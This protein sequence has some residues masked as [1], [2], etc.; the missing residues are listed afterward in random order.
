MGVDDANSACAYYKAIKA[1]PAGRECD[2]E[3]ANP[4]D[5]DSPLIPAIFQPNGITFNEW[6]RDNGFAMNPDANRN[7]NPFDDDNI[8]GEVSALYTNLVDLNLGR[9]MH[10]KK[11]GGDV[12]FYVCNHLTVTDARFNRNVQACVAMDFSVVPGVND[13]KV[14]TKFYVFNPKGEL[15]LAV[16]LDKRGKKFVPGLCVAC[17]GGDTYPGGNPVD[18]NKYLQNPNI[19]THFLPFDLDNFIY[20]TTP[21]TFSKTN[22]EGKFRR[23]NQLIKDTDPTAAIKKLIDIWYPSGTSSQQSKNVPPGWEDNPVTQLNEK[24]LYLDVVKR[25]CRTCHVAART[26]PINFSFNQ[27]KDFMNLR[28]LI[29]SRV[30][31]KHEMPNAVMTFD[32]FWLSQH[33]QAEPRQPR[34]SQGNS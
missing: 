10:A 8:T 26:T 7:G 31:D 33:S 34:H 29:Q 17:H 18:G 20:L 27:F 11:V 4:N 6:K 5:P 30:C 24:D 9:S 25:S 2:M 23:L 28:G 14:F 22:Q 16:D 15:S 21:Q 12:A 32:L 13:G 1:I 19:G 3:P